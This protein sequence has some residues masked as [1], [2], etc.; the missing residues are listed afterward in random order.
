[1]RQKLLISFT[2]LQLGIVLFLLFQDM[3]YPIGF[4]S[5]LIDQMSDSVVHIIYTVW[6]VSVAAN[7]INIYYKPVKSCSTSKLCRL[8]TILTFLFFFS[9]MFFSMYM[10]TRLK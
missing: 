3:I 2:I 10:G 9:L 1:M 6:G 4:G 8:N 5:R 7:F